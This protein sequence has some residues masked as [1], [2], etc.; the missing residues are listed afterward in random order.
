MLRAELMA[1]K[2]IPIKVDK[3]ELGEN[4]TQYSLGSPVFDPTNSSPPDKFIDNITIRMQK[5]YS[6]NPKNYSN[7]NP[8]FSIK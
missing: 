3:K 1:A 8:I 6:E 4:D 2:V 5:Y 7:N